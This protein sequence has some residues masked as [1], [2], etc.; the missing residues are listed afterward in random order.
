MGVNF[1]VEEGIFGPLLRAKFH[2]HRYNVSPLC[3]AKNLKIAIKYRR[4]ALLAI[5]PVMNKTEN[6]QILI[7]QSEQLINFDDGCCLARGFPHG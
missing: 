1:G 6:H 4:F 2:P 7:P 3:G 5:L